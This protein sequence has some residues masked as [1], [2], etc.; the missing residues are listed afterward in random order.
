MTAAAGDVAESRLGNVSAVVI[1]TGADAHEPARLE[2]LLGEIVCDVSRVSV[3]AEATPSDALRAALAAK[4]EGLVLVVSADRPALDADLLIGLAGRSHARAAVPRDA[5]GP[6][7][8]CARYDA[9]PVL[10]ALDGR[11]DA[12]LDGLEVA[13]LEGDA[14][15]TLDD[16]G[17][18]R[19]RVPVPRDRVD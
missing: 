11:G 9:G 2:A 3:T 16:A 18:V 15:A 10:A 6:D 1:D 17:R 12:A 13:W 4:P 8:L 5:H 7:W 19:A 14:L